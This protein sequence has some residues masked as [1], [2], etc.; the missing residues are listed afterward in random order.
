MG[1]A[2]P[3]PIDAHPEPATPAEGYHFLDEIDRFDAS[4]R[5]DDPP[6]IGEWTAAFRSRHAGCDE[7]AFT[8]VFLELVKIDLEN[9]WRRENQRGVMSGEGDGRFHGAGSGRHRWKIED[10]AALL[11]EIFSS[12]PIPI[13]LVTE[14]YR[15][16]HRWGDRPPHGEYASRFPEHVPAIFDILATA[17]GELQRLTP[18]GR[19]ESKEVPAEGDGVPTRRIGEYEIL[20]EIGRGAMGVVYRARRSD[21]DRIVALK[22]VLDGP[23]VDREGLNRLRAEAGAVA[24]LGHPNIVQ[25]YDVG[26]HEGRPY[27]VLEHVPGGDLAQSLAIGPPCSTETAAR[28]VATLARAVHH[29]HARGIVHRDLKP[30]NVLLGAEGEPKI[31]D[32]GLAK[33]LEGGEASTATGTAI[34]T[35]SYMAPEQ[36][37]LVGKAD[38]G[39]AADV[40]ALGAILYE[41]LT[42]RPPFR[43]RRP[44]KHCSWSRSEEPV[45]PS[46]LQ[47]RLPRD[48]ETICLKCLEKSPRRRYADAESLAI[49]L[50]RF[51]AGRSILARPAS[52]PERGWKWSRRRPASAA[53]S[54]P[55]RLCRSSPS[56]RSASPTTRDSAKPFEK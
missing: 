38:I 15:V 53:R 37:G 27:L 34:G 20:G 30:A 52:W 19:S 2:T 23:H 31:T 33:R 42:G 35:P 40:Y 55:C 39:P 21:L 43:R 54:S 10:Y 41:L 12:G 5:F 29:A 6:E 28:L 22:M 45:R 8:D 11:P 17:D 47:P 18:I 26:E 25:I 9:R 56:S 49:D 4:W 32:F 24:R 36:A 3:A 44:G 14:E 16:R 46:R 48:L 13:S 51:L 1:A 7:A 50:D